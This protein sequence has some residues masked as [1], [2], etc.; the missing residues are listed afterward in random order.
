M[1][2]SAQTI[3]A[4]RPVQPFYERMV[5]HG[6]SYGLGPNGYDIRIAEAV[7]IPPRSY[8]LASSV[9]WFDMPLDVMA[10]VEDKSSWARRF[11]SVFNTS[12]DAGWKGYLTLELV[13]HSDQ[14]IVIYEGSPIAKITFQRLDAPTEL[15]YAGAYQ[16]QKPGPQPSAVQQELPG[17]ADGPLF[18][19]RKV[20]HAVRQESD[21]YACMC[22]ARWDCAEG[23]E[24]P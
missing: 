11:L 1:I 13:N 24:H 6:M 5:K 17:L 19:S 21:E 15:R 20:L 2:L 8:A 22:G 23:E 18:Q 7:T 4:L 14:S 9:E 10:R 16:D 3:R 12:I